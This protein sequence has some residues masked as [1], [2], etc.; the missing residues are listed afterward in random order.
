MPTRDSAA[1]KLLWKI[2]ETAKIQ[3][4]KHKSI[5]LEHGHYHEV[6]LFIE[7][8]ICLEADGDFWHMNPN[9]HKYKGKIRAGHKPE[10]IL[11]KDKNNPIK[12]ASD[13]WKQDAETNSA[14]K[15]QGYIVI[16][17]WQSELEENPEKCL[18]EI[19]KAIK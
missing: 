3:F 18:Q 16:R 19:I 1:E 5:G 14:L 2:C 8:N 13:K 4:V 6:D 11:S 15:S 17:F 7:P 12:T 9:P 10:D